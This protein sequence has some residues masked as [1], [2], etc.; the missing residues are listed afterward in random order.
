MPSDASTLLFNQ[1]LKAQLPVPE[2][3]KVCKPAQKAQATGQI[4]SSGG[5]NNQEE[6]EEGAA[7]DSKAPS[8]T[9]KKVCLCWLLPHNAQRRIFSFCSC[10]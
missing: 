10:L 7:E 1:E 8:A 5:D 6:E 2:K 3:A 4:N 9:T